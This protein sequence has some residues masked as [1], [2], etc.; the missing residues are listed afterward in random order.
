MP[1]L[2]LPLRRRGDIEMRRSFGRV[3]ALVIFATCAAA[4]PGM[5]ARAPAA[6]ATSFKDV[7]S[8]P[9]PAPVI[10]PDYSIGAQDTLEITVY[11]VADLSKTVKVES[12]GTI[13]LPLIGQVMASGRTVQQ[14]SDDIAAQFGSKYLKDPLVTVTVKES[15]SQRV[16]VDGAVIQPGVY[17]ISGNT[18]LMQAIALARGP[19]NLADL[20]QVAVFRSTGGKRTEALFDLSSIRSGKTADP[21]ILADDVIIVEQ[22]GGKI[23]LRNLGMAVPFL[24]LLRPY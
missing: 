22:S 24:Q 8:F 3:I 1:A 19:T 23:F 13:A 20:K 15:S 6:P 14:L 5:A 2:S 11:Q 18:T 4:S 21:A 10:A 7:A 16:T 17:P 9:A 12:G